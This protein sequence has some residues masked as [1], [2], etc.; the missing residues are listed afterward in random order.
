MLL[1]QILYGK[2]SV[3]LTSQQ[4]LNTT[5][6]IILIKALIFKGIKH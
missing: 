4:K 3:T 1:G 5:D 2:S 6:Y